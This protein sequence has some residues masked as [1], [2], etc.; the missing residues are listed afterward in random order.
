MY[1]DILRSIEGIGIFPVISLLLF[2]AVFGVVLIWALRADKARLDAHAALPFDGVDSRP[3]EV[4]R[5][6]GAQDNPSTRPSDVE[7]LLRT[8]GAE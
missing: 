2:V 1:A 5:Q 4:A 7:G 8:R 6:R 3:G